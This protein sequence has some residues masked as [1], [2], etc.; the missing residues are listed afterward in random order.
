MIDFK[1][2]PDVDGLRAVAVT[3][4]LLFHA[5]LGFSGGFI[6]VDVFFV[7]SGFLIT[8]LILKE[9]DTGRFSLATFW[10]RRIRR[11]I[12]VATVL[13]VAVL[14]AGFFLLLPSDYAD[15][16][17]STIAQQLMLSNVYFWRHTGYFDGPAELKPLLHTWSLAVEEQFYIIYPFLLTFLKMFGRNVTFGT[18]AFLSIGSL[19][20]SEYGVGHHRSGTFFLLP[21]RAWELLIGGLICFTPKPTR[22]PAWILSVTSWI[23]LASILGVSWCYEATTPFPGLSALVPCAATAILIYTNAA[24]LTLPAA[25]LATKP[26]VF[27]GLMSYSLYLW[28]WPLFAFWRGLYGEPGITAATTMLLMST[29]IAYFSWRFVETPLRRSVKVRPKAFYYCAAMTSVVCI[30]SIAAGI[31]IQ[32]GVKSRFPNASE[33]LA[34]TSMPRV[35]HCSL[36]DA[37]KG[38]FPTVGMPVDS[39]RIVFWG[40]SHLQSL[41]DVIDE[42]LRAE[43]TGAVFASHGGY[44]PLLDAWC[45][46]RPREDVLRWN[47]SV[48][49][50]IREHEV[51]DVVL[52]ARWTVYIEGRPNGDRD[53]LITDSDGATRRTG[54]AKATMERSLD[55]TIVALREAGVRVW[56]LTEVPSQVGDPARRIVAARFLNGGHVTGT[57]REWND[58]RHRAAIEI[59]E[60]LESRG[61]NI[62]DTWNYCF[63]ES[64]NSMIFDDRGCF[65][66]DDNHLSSYGSHRLLRS[67]C[68]QLASALRQ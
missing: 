39:P 55:R 37:V 64:G 63:D 14:V 29:I 41:F 34:T 23:S 5:G 48:I 11:I 21:T 45:I 4:V 18:L 35:P 16:A 12:P 38:D 54:D 51:T 52:V 7:I 46:G 17:K 9:Q 26:V 22:V 36:E 68:E 44:F 53:M 33:F 66:K 32:E 43:G 56:I 30:T 13:V 61:V 10:V 50:Y 24:R 3:L 47:Q 57:T 28:H 19:A 60:R 25:I 2:R 42:A 58:R 31:W 65:Y 1:Y 59:I 62:L 6:G 20:L 8:G 49:T 27:V 15:L 40:D 67:M